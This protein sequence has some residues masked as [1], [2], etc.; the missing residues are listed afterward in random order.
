MMDTFPYLITAQAKN[1]LRL[2]MMDDSQ[3]AIGKEVDYIATTLK[4]RDQFNT[5]SDGFIG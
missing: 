5:V 3:T 1:D 4:A 2:K